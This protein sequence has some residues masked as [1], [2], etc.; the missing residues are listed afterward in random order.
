MRPE[1]KVLVTAHGSIDTRAIPQH[2]K[3]NLAQAA[4]RSILQAYNDPAVRSDYE[5]WKAERE[6]AVTHEAAKAPDPE[7][8]D[9]G[10]QQGPPPRQLPLGDGDRDRPDC[11]RQINRHLGTGTER[12]NAGEKARNRHGLGIHR[13]GN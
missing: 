12:M 9:S 5:R 1:P 6:R 7:A 13:T 2:I 8:E 10:E 11:L 3:E 4:F